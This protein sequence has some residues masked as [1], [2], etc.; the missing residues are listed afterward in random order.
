M[1]L[2]TGLPIL[3][4][5]WDKTPPA[6]QAVVIALWQENLMHKQQVTMLQN[7]VTTLQAEVEKLGERVNKNSHNSSK[8]T[9]FRCTPQ[10]HLSQART[11]RAE[12]GWAERA[13]WERTKA[14]TA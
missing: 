1:D 2:P 7:Q 14:Q 8:A 6:A 5:D 11:N 13:S 4:S 9:F 3:Q 12:E 10:A